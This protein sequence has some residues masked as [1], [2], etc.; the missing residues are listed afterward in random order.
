MLVLLDREQ[1]YLDLLRPS[2]NIAKIAGSTLGVHKFDD[3]KAK[4]SKALKGVYAGENSPLFGRT[5]TEETLLLMSQSHQGTNNIKYGK[6]HT[7]QTKLLMSLAK[8]GKTRAEKTKEA[9]SVENG[10]TVYLYAACL[11]N[12]T[13]AFCLIGKYTSLRKL[14]KSLGISLSNVSRYLKSGSLFSRGGLSYKLSLSLL[15][16]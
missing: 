15:D 13:E 10:T 8:K 16:K 7:E 6:T 12:S 4:I 5:H 2:Y 9:I 3:T 11:E 14:G 1:Y